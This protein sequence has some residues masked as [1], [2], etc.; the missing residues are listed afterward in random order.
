MI[1]KL[2]QNQAERVKIG[3]WS[4][5]P[6]KIS[7]IF[8][9]LLVLFLPTQLGKHFWPDWSFVYGLRLDY[10]SPTIYFTDILILLIFIFSLP[11]FFYELKQ[12]QKK[13]LFGFLLLLLSFLVGLMG[14]KNYWVGI[15]GIIKFLE[16][17]FLVYFVAKNYK[18]LNR[19]IL[20]CCFLLSI[21]VETL[22]TFLQYLNQGSIGG[23]FYL[24]G[25]RAF[26]AE[27]PGI[28]NASINGQLF[29]RPYAT[30]SHPNVLAGFLV[31]SMLFLFLFSFKNQR[32]KIFVFLGSFLGTAALLAT[33]S[34]TAI[35]LWL[36]YLIVLFGL[37]VFEKYKKRKF[38]SQ[39]L[40]LSMLVFAA[41]TILVIL[42]NNF[43]LQRFLTTRLSDESLIQ[44]QELVTESL[45]MFWK[46]PVLGIG[47]N[48]Y[49]NNLNIVS[50]KENT[51]LIQPVH[52]IFLLTLAEMGL[53]GFC[54]MLL[55]FIKSCVTAL[56]KKQIRKYLLMAIF[57]IIF[58]G[59]FDHYFLTLQQGQ[60]LFALVIG[61]SLSKS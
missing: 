4:L 15:Y 29:L 44:R 36:A 53:I 11:R 43:I 23:I 3:F 18:S 17:S 39:Q 35:L 49:F 55:I 9:Y 20:F 32:L 38:N 31:L 57:A 54:F 30:F 2:L 25:E 10:L 58:L 6:S 7:K 60:L 5:N 27:T 56:N 24:F 8:F 13:Y 48:N 50:S 37:W 47:V 14:A 59:M 21:T 41:I 40:T 61:F 19:V 46:S 42:Q 1:K 16:F 12:I 51:F 26:N 22:L 28:A 33:L 52:N 34:R 45:N